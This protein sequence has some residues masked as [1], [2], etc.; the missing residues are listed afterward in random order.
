M[1]KE[2]L[3]CLSYCPSPVQK[4]LEGQGWAWK[5]DTLPRESP[6]PYEVS[7]LETWAGPGGV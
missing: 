2:D 7:E 5:G 3:M 4:R 6:G 1:C